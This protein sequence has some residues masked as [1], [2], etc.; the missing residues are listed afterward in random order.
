MKVRAT[1]NIDGFKKGKEY[2]LEEGFALGMIACGHAERVTVAPFHEREKA[3]P[4]VKHEKRSW[5]TK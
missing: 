4:S 5:L 2:D 1:V 3:I